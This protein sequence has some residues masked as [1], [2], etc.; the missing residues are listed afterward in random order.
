MKMLISRFKNRRQ[1]SLAVATAAILFFAVQFA[2]GAPPQSRSQAQP[3]HAAF[4]DDVAS[5]LLSQI[6]SGF[7]SRNQNKVLAAFDLAAMPDGQLFKQQIIAFFAHT[8]SVNIHFNLVQTSEED[9]KG[10]AQAD[11]EL[12][13][14]PRDS[15]TLPVHK[16][17]RLVFTAENTPVGWKFSDVQPRS[18]FSLQESTSEK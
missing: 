10:T 5:D 13:A 17:E 9:G 11:V 4:T 1:S 2:A 16:Q 7:E 3:G 12:E 15:N 6:V 8:E 14:S 18:F